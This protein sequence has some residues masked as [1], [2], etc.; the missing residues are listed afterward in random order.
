MPVGGFKMRVRLDWIL[1]T[2]RRKN[3]KSLKPPPSAT[4]DREGEEMSLVFPTVF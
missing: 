1:S 2:P 3:D 4:M